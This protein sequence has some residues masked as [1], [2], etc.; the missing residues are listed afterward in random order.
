MAED[1]R[2][3]VQL[4]EGTVG[5]YVIL[6]GDRGR[7]KR[8]A[9]YLDNP[10]V[11]GDNREYFTMT[12]TLDGE[13]VSVMSTGMGAPCV[14]IGIEELRTLGV[15]TYIRVGTAGAL[16]THLNMGDGVIAMG[17]I[18][19]DGTMSDYLPKAYPAVGHFEVIQALNEAAAAV[20]HPHHT[21]IV[22]STDAY[23]ARFFNKSELADKN[24]RYA[25]AHALCVEMEVSCLYVLASIYDLR[26]GAI[27]T[28][29]EVIDEQSEYRDQA[30]TAYEEVLELSIL[31]SVEAIRLLI[32][33][34]RS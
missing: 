13:K 3:H 31:T 11:V 34:D 22:L 2:Y 26:A 29:R 27:V 9:K 6:P 17:A 33:K 32:R 19:E 8:I 16:Q 14:S 15:H 28:V 21:G 23:Y 25:R 20:H 30:G 1:P 4:K 5:N 10:E 12:G 24:E 18:R 7:V